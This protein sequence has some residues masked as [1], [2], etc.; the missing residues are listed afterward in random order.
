MKF[1]PFALSIA[2]VC[3]ALFLS[4][5]EMGVIPDITRYDYVPPE[6]KAQPR[7][8][9][10]PPPLS[11]DQAWPRLGDVPFKPKDFSPKPVY[12]HYMDELDFER[13]EAQDAKKKAEEAAPGIVNPGASGGA[14]TNPPY[15][16]IH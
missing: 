13:V 2:L 3:A 15:G 12:L 9:E 7:L 8:V 10:T 5:C 6:V 4:G 1:A 11:P 14:N 16:E